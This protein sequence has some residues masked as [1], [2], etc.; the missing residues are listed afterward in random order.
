MY[1]YNTTRP[2]IPL[3]AY[4]RHIT[5]LV[6]EVAQYPDREKR[7]A[8]ARALVNLMKRVSRQ[9]DPRIDYDP[10][11]WADLFVIS[12]Y[13]LDVDS[14]YSKPEKKEKKELAKTKMA[15]MPQGTYHRFFG[16]YLT[17]FI[18][19]VAE[20]LGKDEKQDEK[21]IIEL[22]K[23]AQL[24]HKKEANGYNLLQHIEGII[25]EK[26]PI[27]PDLERVLAKKNGDKKKNY[28]IFRNEKK[29]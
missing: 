25:G 14:P 22:I 18:H 19:K 16:K 9:V 20:Q 4:G 6:K 21:R 2:A 5:E 15:Y 24:V 27:T 26:I 13:E 17:A 28:S 11:V 3:K 8:Q 29:Y 10:K 7:N 12:D 23:C 1:E